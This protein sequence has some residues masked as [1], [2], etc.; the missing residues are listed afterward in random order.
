M[1]SINSSNISASYLSRAQ[2]QTNSALNRL[3]SGYRINSASDD[4][5]GVS[6]AN[7]MT[8]EITGLNM[9]MKNASDGISLTQTA[10]GALSE[11]TSAL[12]RMRE[13]AVQSSN[14][15]YTSTDR[16]AMN[17]EFSQLQS[18]LS[19]ISDQTTFN[20]QQ[21]LN[22]DFSDQSY[23]VGANSGETIEVTIGD[24]S[25]EGLGLSGLD[26]S[27]V[28]GAQGAL[29]AIDEALVTVSDT[30][31]GLGAAQGSFD[32]A[33][34]NLET[35]SENMSAA[36]SRVEDADYAEEVSKM[37]QGLILQKAAIAMQAQANS[38]AETTLRLLE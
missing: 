2:Q 12:Q 25:L 35:T 1:V 18:E 10:D 31:G 33:I 37:T 32:S 8:S 29:E 17:E 16:A 36:R 34:S 6:I 3:S 22:G 9:A 30:R 26:I 27:T 11:S 20:G 5:A 4:A 15:I 14:G 24:M 38:S 7:R 19:R 28:D 13:L 21:L 23:Q